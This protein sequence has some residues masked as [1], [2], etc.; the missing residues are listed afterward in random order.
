M[1]L[2]CIGNSYSQ[3]ACTYMH[4]MADA[5]GFWLETRN[6]YIGGCSLERHYANLIS[7]E[8]AYNYEVN[9][10]VHAKKKISIDE[11]LAEAEWDAVSIQQVSTKSGLYETYFPYATALAERIRSVCP[12]ARLLVHETWAYEVS[13]PHDYGTQ[14]DMHRALHDAYY[15][16]AK[17]IGADAVVPTGDVIAELRKNAFFDVTRGG[18]SLCRDGSHL[19]LSYGRYTAGATFCEVL[20]VPGLAKNPFLPDAEGTAVTREGIALVK[21][22]VARVVAQSAGLANG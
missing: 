22:A 12:R 21:E 15:R 18:E 11:A 10:D 4:R 14:A 2:L 9:G 5:V 16:V 3:D 19:S 6:L 7:G 1:K 20:G 8:A 13:R 17:E